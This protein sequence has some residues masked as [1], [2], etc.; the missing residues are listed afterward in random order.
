LLVKLWQGFDRHY[1][2]KP[3]GNPDTNH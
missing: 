3:V 1:A 2:Q